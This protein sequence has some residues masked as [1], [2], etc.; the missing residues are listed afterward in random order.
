MTKVSIGGYFA[1][2]RE[3]GMGLDWIKDATGYQSA[4]SAT[5]AVLTALQPTTV[6]VPNFICG[7]INDTL[8]SIHANV[9]HYAL[10]ESLD[11]PGTVEL[12][13]T[14]LLICIDYFGINGPAVHRAIDHF[15]VGRVLVDASQS[16]FFNHQPGCTTVY[17]PRK[18]VGVPDGGLL[19]T[20][21]QLAPRRTA[22]EA[23]SVTRSQHLLYR[24]AD[25]TDVGYTKFQEAEASLSGCEPVAMS[26]ITKAMLMSINA[27]KVATMR[28]HNYQRLAN[29][30]RASGFDVPLL[31]SHAVPLCC[32]V[33]CD[34]AIRIRNELA[35]RCI[36]TPTYWADA[37]IPEDDY[38]ALRMRDRTVYLPC[39]Q[40]Y[41]EPELLRLA[42]AMIQL[43][44]A[45]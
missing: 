15:G 28:V 23:D 38:A 24:L 26:Q 29:L 6:W 30:L 13:S 10:T 5:A 41:G 44:G 39:D 31:P 21:L 14:D 32:P 43:E 1:L 16:L 35:A 11:V 36:F 2:E 37:I 22:A 17:S 18:F 25:L 8:R 3:V 7:A 45:S 33:R 19:R 34:E 12:A 20:S 42:N 9:R 40:R 4:R 27:E